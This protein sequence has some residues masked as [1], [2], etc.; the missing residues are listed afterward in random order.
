MKQSVSLT[1]RGVCLAWG[2]AAIA[3]W[4]GCEE[5]KGLRG[6][7]IDP[8]NVTVTPSSN[9]VVFTVT[10]VTNLLALPLAW[11]VTDPSVGTIIA[12]SGYTALYRSSRRSGQNIVTARDQYGNEGHAT[13]KHISEQYDLTVSASPATIPAGQNMTTISVEGGQA[14]YAWSVGDSNAGSIV[15]GG[16][17]SSAVYRSYRAGSNAVTVRDA[18]GVRASVAVV[19]A[20]SSGSG[21]NPAN[22]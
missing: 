13:V 18:N 7:R 11:S 14:P 22:P 2:L 19:Q 5:A 17:G 1:S 10:G 4:F 3:G 15:A 9:T 16:S 20:A 12:N 21:A 8:S 6:L